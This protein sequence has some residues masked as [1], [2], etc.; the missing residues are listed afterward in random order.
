MH[1]G[2]AR[3]PVLFV[4]KAWLIP[5]FPLLGAGLAVLGAQRRMR[6]EAHIPVVAGIG[7]GFPGLAR[8]CCFPPVRT[9]PTTVMRWLT[10]SDLEIPIEFRVDG[11][12]TMMLSM[13]TF[14]STL[15]AVFAA[16]YMAGDP[17]LSAVLRLDRSFRRIDDG[18]RPFQ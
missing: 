3:C 2:A 4:R 17:A 16:G 12:T 11:L 5:F 15:V 8:S 1:P 13:V 9:R 6:T 18:S 14:V 7:A 10:I